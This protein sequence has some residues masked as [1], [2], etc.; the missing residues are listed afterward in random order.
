MVCQHCGKQGRDVAKH[1][2][3]KCTKV[4]VMCQHCNKEHRKRKEAEHMATF[5]GINRVATDLCAVTTLEFP[6]PPADARLLLGGDVNSNS[7]RLKKA[8]ACN[9]GARLR[10]AAVTSSTSSGNL[11]MRIRQSMR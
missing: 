7:R 3:D 9:A 1:V 10:M 8:A 5:Q 4:K 11:Q 6:V 2:R